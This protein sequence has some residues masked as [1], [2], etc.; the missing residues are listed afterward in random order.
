[1]RVGGPKEGQSIWDGFEQVRKR[2]QTLLVHALLELRPGLGRESI[3]IE[4]EIAAVILRVGGQ[5]GIVPRECR[6]LA[7]DFPANQFV[8]CPLIQ[9]PRPFRRLYIL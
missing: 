1:M 6:A 2:L 3:A 5:F 4:I 7:N 8:F 9:V